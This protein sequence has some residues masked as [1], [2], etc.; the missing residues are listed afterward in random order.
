MLYLD[1]AEFMII[2]ID[3]VIFERMLNLKF[4]LYIFDN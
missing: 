3:I 2:N 4:Y 1:K